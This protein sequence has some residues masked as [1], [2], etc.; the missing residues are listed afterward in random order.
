MIFAC[1]KRTALTLTLKDAYRID[2]AEHV[3]KLEY[4]ANDV[5]SY[6]SGMF[7]I[8]ILERRQVHP[9]AQQQ[10]ITT[11]NRVLLPRTARD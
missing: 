8:V 7:S 5:V 6:V 11:P 2:T 1:E 10:H 9:S 4:A 3:R